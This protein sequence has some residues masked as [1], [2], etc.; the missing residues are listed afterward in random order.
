VG[1]DWE[2]INNDDDLAT[3]VEYVLESQD[4][5]HLDRG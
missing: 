2:C 5:K 1:G 4:R 3:V